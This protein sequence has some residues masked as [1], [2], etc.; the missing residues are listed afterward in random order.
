MKLYI[1]PIA[2]SNIYNLPRY[3]KVSQTSTKHG[4]AVKCDAFYGSELSGIEEPIIKDRIIVVGSMNNKYGVT[5]FSRFSNIGDRVDVC[6]PGEDLI[7]PFWNAD[8]HSDIYEVSKEYEKVDGI[9]FSAPLIASLAAMIY[10]VNPDIKA[11][12]VKKLICN[13]GTDTVTTS[14]NGKKLSY[15]SRSK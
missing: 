11:K 7:A 3:N 12:Q 1:Q 15:N 13:I 9:S 2:I 5:E 6:A 8:N 4:I 14:G 10:Q